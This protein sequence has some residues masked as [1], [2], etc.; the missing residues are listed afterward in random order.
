MNDM[1]DEYT[2]ACTLRCLKTSSAFFDVSVFVGC[3]NKPFER[4]PIHCLLRAEIWHTGSST[5]AISSVEFLKH[6]KANAQC[7]Q[8]CLHN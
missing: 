1:Y 6:A 2:I 7:C 4:A 5:A 8:C 3:R